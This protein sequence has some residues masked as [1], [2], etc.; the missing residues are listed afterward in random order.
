MG[1]QHFF[2]SDPGTGQTMPVT[3]WPA[4]NELFCILNYLLACSDWV[5]QVYRL[6]LRE[7]GKIHLYRASIPW[8]RQHG[9]LTGLWIGGAAHSGYLQGP[10]KDEDIIFFHDK[11]QHKAAEIA[12]MMHELTHFFQ[13]KG[14]Q[15]DHA[16]AVQIIALMIKNYLMINDHRNRQNFANYGVNLKE[17]SAQELMAALNYLKHML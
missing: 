6:G 15:A 3:A 11:V 17:L 5:N 10:H 2:M 4:E 9:F 12:L 8:A 1:I 14:E 16:R 7:T 13:G